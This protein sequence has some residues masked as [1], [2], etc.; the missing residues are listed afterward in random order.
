MLNLNKCTK[1][2]PK[3][4]PTLIFMN[5]SCVCVSLCTSQKIIHNTEQF[6]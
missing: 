4:K 3:R 1:T 6:W 2:K 5:C